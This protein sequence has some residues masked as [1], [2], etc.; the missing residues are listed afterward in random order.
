MLSCWQSTVSEHS[1]TASTVTLHRCEWQEQGSWTGTVRGDLHV[2]AP[3]LLG[4]LV[5]G[6]STSRRRRAPQR[7]GRWWAPGSRAACWRWAALGGTGWKWLKRTETGGNVRNHTFTCF[8]IEP[9]GSVTLR[10][11]LFNSEEYGSEH[12]PLFPLWRVDSVHSLEVFTDLSYYSCSFFAYIT[13][14]I[15]IWGCTMAYIPASLDINVVTGARLQ[16]VS[17]QRDGNTFLVWLI[18]K[19]R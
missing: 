9:W 19:K 1:L 4:R 12:Q 7:P 13:S 16:G 14:K 8:I 3:V 5:C 15:I 17:F 18:Q 10:T 11:N 6:V 2:W